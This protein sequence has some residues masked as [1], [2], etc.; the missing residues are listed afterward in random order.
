MRLH[1]TP[2]SPF[3]RMIRV[4]LRE[5]SLSCDEMAIGGFP[6]PTD[7]F[8]VNPMGQVPALET[9]DGIRFPTRL[10]IDHLLALPRSI[11]M[12][13]AASVRRDPGN[14]QDEQT[15]TIILAMGDAMAALKYQE[16][17][18]LQRGGTDLIGFDPAARHAERVISTLDWLEGRATPDGFMPGV[19]SAQDVAVSCLLLWADARGGFPWRGHPLLEAIIGRCAVRPSFIDTAPQPW[20]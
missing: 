17:A 4:L 14:W 20:P 6:P 12:P 7:Y 8:R 15:M 18:G 3:A 10:I 19:L 5:L 1:F 11:A 16:W 13:I 2:G 9:E